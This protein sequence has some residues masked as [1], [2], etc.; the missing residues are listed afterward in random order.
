MTHQKDPLGTAG[1]TR[2]FVTSP[3]V[4]MALCGGGHTVGSPGLWTPGWINMNHHESSLVGGV[5]LPF[6]PIYWE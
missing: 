1:M 6:F 4:V 2:W 3:A 5:E